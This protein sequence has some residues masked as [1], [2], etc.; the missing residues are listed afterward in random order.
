MLGFRIGVFSAVSGLELSMSK[1]HHQCVILMGDLQCHGGPF[2]MSWNVEM[3]FDL[4]MTYITENL[5]AMGFPTGGM[6]SGFFGYVEGFYCNHMEEVVQFFETYHK[7]FGWGSLG[8]TFEVTW[9][10]CVLV[11][12]VLW[13]GWAASCAVLGINWVY[14]LGSKL[15]KVFCAAVSC[16]L[17]LGD[18]AVGMR[19]NWVRLTVRSKEAVFGCFCSTT[20]DCG[21]C[22]DDIFSSRLPEDVALFPFSRANGTE[23]ISVT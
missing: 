13:V 19:R 7:S 12:S 21:S 14:K 11:K 1:E 23:C 6:S 4:D 8:C 2:N 3:G 15:C 9:C 17:L 10:V 20:K 18:C 16:S 22:G 5:I